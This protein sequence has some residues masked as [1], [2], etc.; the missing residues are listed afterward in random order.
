MTRRIM[1][2]DLRRWEVFASAGPHGFSNPATLVFRCLSD[3]E[4]PSRAI[5]FPGD[6]S[7]AEEAVLSLE[8]NELE[9][10]L[11]EAQPLS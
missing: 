5:L 11:N 3:R 10:Q 4:E 7:K 2:R 9:R 8:A 1:D 6:R